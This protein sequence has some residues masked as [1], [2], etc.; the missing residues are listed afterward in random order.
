MERVPRLLVVCGA[1]MAPPEAGFLHAITAN[2][3]DDT[4]RLVY[5]DWLD[6]QGERDRASYLRLQVELVRTWWYDN[7]CTD[8]FAR[9]TDLTKRV[10][11]AW[12][13]TVRRCTTPA[14]PVNVEEALP[15]LRGK[16]KTAVRLHPRPGEAAVDASKIGGMFLWPKR[17]PW[18]TCPTHNTPYVTALQLRKQDVPELGFPDGTDL[19]QLLWCPESHNDNHMYCPMPQVFWR[20]RGSVKQTRKTAPALVPTDGHYP[21]R[22]NPCVIYPE[23]QIEYPDPSEHDPVGYGDEH[24]IAFR[25]A[26][27][28]GNQLATSSG[29]RYC[30]GDAS[31]LY[32]WWLSTAEG[33]K[34]G[35]YPDWVQDRYYPRCECGEEMEHLLS[36]ASLEYDGATWGRWVPIEDRPILDATGHRA[37]DPVNCAT[38]CMFGDCGNMYVFV[39]RKHGVWPIRASMQCC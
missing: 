26:V 39:C 31:H 30:P 4:A 5:A 38:G 15:E 33:T 27:S 23:R 20:Q 32:Q 1:T 14:P 22:P 35:G 8:L 12:L 18:P 16:A 11:P 24:E 6:E 2:R 36:F 29:T 21:I 13:A 10:D 17:E 7:P 19:F 9:F 37:Q 3:R 34:V 28:L 25:A